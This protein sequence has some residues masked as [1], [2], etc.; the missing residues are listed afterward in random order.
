MIVIINSAS[1]V[2]AD[3]VL[4]LH[5]NDHEVT[6]NRPIAELTFFDRRTTKAIADSIQSPVLWRGLH[7]FDVNL[8]NSRLQNWTRKCDNI[9]LS[10]D[11][12]KLLILTV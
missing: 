7:L 11:A 10:C 9:S 6:M 3:V 1:P 8:L 4:S 2:N 12:N 5:S